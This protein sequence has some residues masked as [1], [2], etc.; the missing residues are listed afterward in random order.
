MSAARMDIYGRMKDGRYIDKKKA[1]KIKRKKNSINRWIDED[2]EKPFLR[3]A[4]LITGKA[5][6]AILKEKNK[7]C[8]VDIY[9]DNSIQLRHLFGSFHS[10]GH[11]LLIPTNFKE[12]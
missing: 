8:C 5:I 9:P 7:E 6:T 3:S 1:P 2:K 12:R 11:L 4:S 10:A